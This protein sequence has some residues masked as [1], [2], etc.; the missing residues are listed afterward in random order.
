MTRAMG[1]STR[2]WLLIATAL[3]TGCRDRG[4]ADPSAD[5]LAKLSP[6]VFSHADE[7]TADDARCLG[8]DG[9]LISATSIG[10][11]RLGRP[12]Q[13]LRQSCPIAQVKVPASSQVEGPVLGASAGGG[14]ILFTVSGKDSTVETA[15]T[16]SP[17][18]RASNGVGVGS[19]VR[20]TPARAS[21]VCF[22]RISGRVMEVFVSRRP[23]KC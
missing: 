12:L 11:V 19:V 6:E 20:E 15:G 1:R 18:F 2:I 17:A 8:A 22:K 3:A 9:I 4:P 5:Q 10:P 16:S 21:T 14:L 13:S 7:A 23:L